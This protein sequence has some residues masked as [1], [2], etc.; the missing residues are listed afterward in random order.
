MDEQKNLI[1]AVAAAMAIL[2][3]FH[4]FYEK[5]MQKQAI[6]KQQAQ[7]LAQAE[8]KDAPIASKA[9]TGEDDKKE[10][11]RGVAVKTD[12]RV[13]INTKTLHGSINLKGGYID[14]LT[15][16]QYK[17][18]IDP[19][20]PEVVL[21]S[22][23]NTKDAYFS[24]FSWKVV[25]ASKVVELPTEASLWSLVSQKTE[26]VNTV[27]HLQWKNTSG[28]IFNRYITL[29]DLY[30]FTIKDEVTNQSNDPISLTHYGKILR[31]GTPEVSG[32][33]ILH[34][35]PLGILNGKL[36]EYDYKKLQKTNVITEKT[37]GG[38]AGITDKYWLVSALAPQEETVQISY[39]CDLLSS[40]NPVYSVHFDKPALAIEAGKSVSS[41]F[42]FFAGAKVLSALDR[43]EESL[44]I[45]NF[46]LAV[47]FGWF[48]FLTKPLFYFIDWI[49]GIVGNFG[50]SI[51][52]LTVIVRLLF[53]PLANKSFKSMARMRRLQPKM[54]AIKKRFEHDKMRMNQELM[55]LYQKEKV[56]PMG[57]CLPMLIQAPVFFCLYKV[58]FVSIEMRHAPF[59]GWINDLSAPDP[60]NL[61]NLF[62]L[63]PWEAP[64]FLHI[65]L[66]PLLM[67]GTMILQQRLNPQPTDPIQAKM[68]MLMPI[69]FTFL[70]ASFPAG[71]VI[72]WA[73]SNILS[74]AQQATLIKMEERRI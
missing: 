37:T 41:T 20:A 7:Q 16:A 29:D 34:E 14:D 13:A 36:Q 56:N 30:M 57:G 62:G 48:Y 52:V 72:Y 24:F 5:P 45:K 63:I 43:Y 61:F 31:K 3:G 1:I 50:L 42:H 68:F 15:L 65:G 70:F 51:L 26:G 71:L 23:K 40:T 69:A 59:Y 8:K 47:D 28:L 64:S 4:Y 60:T 67:G 49:K 46:D 74:I 25:D 22:P 55:G 9:V 33:Y 6:E 10:V 39:N 35:G 21:L 11:E 12:N 58:L 2:L 73:W 19:D 53:F 32:N 17:E 54:E 66:L 18:D 44:K 27:Y 38:W